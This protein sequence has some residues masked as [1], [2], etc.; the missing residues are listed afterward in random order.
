MKI[1]GLLFCVAAYGCGVVEGDRLT[2]KDLA[3]AHGGFANLDPSLDIGPAPVAGAVR[4][5]RR[6]E[7]ERVAKEHGIQLE[8]DAPREV[9]VQRAAQLVRAELLKQTLTE[10]FREEGREV[11]VEVLDFSRTPLP[12]GKLEFPKS[13]LNAT[14]TWRGRLVYG[15]NR[16]IPVWARVAVHDVRTG[17]AVVAGR[18][19]RE[20][21]VA[22]GETIRVEVSSGGVVL[23][24]DAAAESSGHVG[25]AI[26]VRNP[27]N[28]QKFR[29][30]VE[31][32]GKAGVRK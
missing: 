26:T 12:L 28:G 8:A 27:G 6:T 3:A 19:V 23:A 25:E 10:V 16:S 31:A 18:A 30:I 2:G 17:D 1:L 29:A 9:C 21:Q 14:G 7:L 5:L 4:T 24:F 32:R 20:A 11:D 22:R 13:G 15:E